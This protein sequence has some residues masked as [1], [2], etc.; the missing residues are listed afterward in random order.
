[1]RLP[2]SLSARQS[3]EWHTIAAIFAAFIAIMTRRK[4]V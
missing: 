3:R 2:I 4:W 1:L